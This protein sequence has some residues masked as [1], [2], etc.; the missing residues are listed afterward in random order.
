MFM[1]LDIGF[2]GRDETECVNY[3]ERR[4]RGIWID[5]VEREKMIVG[6]HTYY[7]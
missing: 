2:G 5:T 1:S 3:L 6:I 4:C 7:K